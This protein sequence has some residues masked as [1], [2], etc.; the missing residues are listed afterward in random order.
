MTQLVAMGTFG[1]G[2]EGNMANKVTL[3]S[4]RR[5]REVDWDIVEEVYNA[6]PLYFD[7][8]DHCA[9]VV[10]GIDEDTDTIAMV[11]AADKADR[12]MVPA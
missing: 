3:Q 4:G 10:A 9:R 11:L 7:S 5:F 2:K 12:D 1:E 8:L 6:N